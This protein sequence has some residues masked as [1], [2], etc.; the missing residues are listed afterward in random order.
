MNVMGKIKKGT[1]VRFGHVKCMDVERSIKRTNEAKVD[2]I[3]GRDASKDV[4][5]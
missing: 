3:S 1:F 2:G 5:K 4:V